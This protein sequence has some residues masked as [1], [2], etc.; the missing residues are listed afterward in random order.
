MLALD[1]AVSSYYELVDMAKK[2]GLST[3]G[4]SAAIRQRLYKY[5]GLQSPVRE[6]G[7][8]AITIE[9]AASLEY[10]TME[11]SGN[12]AIKLTGPLKFKANTADGF[13]HSISADSLVYDKTANILEAYGNITY[14]RQGNGKTDTFKGS[15]LI[16]NLNDY[17]GVFLDGSFNLEPIG[18]ISRTTIFHFD[19][20][21]R[22]SD[23]LMILGKARL[24]ACDAEPPHYQIKAD[25]VWLFGNGDWALS[26]ATLYLGSVPVLWLPYFYFPNGEPVFHPVFGYRLREGAFVQ[27]TTYLLGQKNGDTST[28]SSLSVLQ[29]NVSGSTE[30]S[31]I[32]IRRKTSNV[33]NTSTQ[34]GS[35]PVFGS[36]SGSS[37]KSGQTLKLLADVY[38]S[39][40]A[41]IGLTGSFP[42]SRGGSLDFSVDV[43]ASRSIFQQSSGFYSPFDVSNGYKSVWNSTYIFGIELPMRF[44]VTSSWKTILKGKSTSLAVDLS[45]PLYSDPFFEQDFTNRNESSNLF[46]MMSTQTTTITERTSY[47]QNAGLV[48]S[49]NPGMDTGAAGN[50]IDS[51]NVSKFNTQMS[52]KSKQEPTSGLTTAQYTLLSVDP[53][54]DFF[55]PD[56][57]RPFDTAIALTG[58]LYT[59]KKRS[60]TLLSPSS[61]TNSQMA[62]TATNVDQSSTPAN[63]ASTMTSSSQGLLFTLGWIANG[64]AYT[65]DKFYS[66]AWTYPKDIDLALSYSMLSWKGSAGITSNLGVGGRL[67]SISTSTLVSAQDQTR[68]YLYDDR[69]SPTTVHPLRLSDYMYRASSLQ[70]AVT[71]TFMPFSASGPWSASNLSYAI[72]AFW[73]HMLYQGLSGSGTGAQPVYATTWLGWDADSITTHSLTTT[74]VL[75]PGNLR[76]SFAISANLPPQLEKYSIGY[77]VDISWAHVSTQAVLSQT[78]VATPIVPS[79]LTA[80]VSLGK[81]PFP[82]IASDFSW[83][84]TTNA[85]LLSATTLSYKSL[86][87]RY[88]M[89]KSSGYS[90]AAG[91][92]VADG[93]EFFRPYECSLS[94]A[95]EITLGKQ[96]QS[97]QATL[98]DQGRI[99]GTNERDK[100]A[101]PGF[102]FGGKAKLSLSQNLLRFTESTLSA[103]FDFS[104]TNQSGFS[105]SFSSVSANNSAWRYYASL[106]PATATL[107]PNS[108]YKNIFT[109]LFQS[110]S[111]WDTAALSNSL[112]KLQNLS[113]KMAADLHDWNVS[114]AV[115]MS[116]YLVTPTTGRA[117]Y[118]MDFSFTFAVTWKDIPDLKKTVQYQDG[119]FVQ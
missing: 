29:G 87:A 71:A 16:V 48:F 27:T 38:S 30:L 108:Y 10:L 31:G 67:L 63:V 81:D 101:G 102:M 61:G 68:P 35:S 28:L 22:R 106:F 58:T 23:D 32:F 52:W 105:I 94:F 88:V 65:E 12:S 7:D 34:A 24:T 49:W 56:S 36:A 86:S 55:Y 72:S 6:K 84:F 110:F 42:D 78:A 119:A 15:S 113:L 66:L 83:D 95:P 62:A 47:S 92:W 116:P 20:V 103:S 33:S 118:Q 80:S 96:A 117:Y 91:S 11:G 109:D 44:G 90:Y 19:K 57:L 50:L 51:L 18:Q 5:L 76:Q 1:I 2:Y 107:D 45:V 9:S 73:Y 75:S 64:S 97:A 43:A 21:I 26:N 53:R 89:K 114:A 41:M 82:T 46:G 37:Q 17:N 104:L 99:T 85:P 40:G 70:T 3:E 54:R 115:G 13:V 93:I 112:F 69:S 111:I 98:L 39:L 8:T 77:A 25:K 14:T 100:S 4:D 59:N 60:P 74:L 79:S